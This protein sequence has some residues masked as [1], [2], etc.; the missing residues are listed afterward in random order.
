M[1]NDTKPDEKVDYVMDSFADGKLI[2]STYWKGKHATVGLFRLTRQF[3]RWHLLVPSQHED[4]IK[5]M[6]TAK[7]SVV[8]KGHCRA[9][10]LRAQGKTASDVYSVFAGSESA[11]EYEAIEL[12]FEDESNYP[13]VLTLHEFQS[14]MSSLPLRGRMDEIDVIV[15]RDGVAKCV[16][17]LKCGFRE[18]DVPCAKPWT[19]KSITNA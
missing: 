17:T 1:S 6:E 2:A 3:R 7:Y 18:A 5:Q 8:T 14:A 16:L 15:E 9:S 13:F 19:G 11:E 10:V 12:L 4:Q